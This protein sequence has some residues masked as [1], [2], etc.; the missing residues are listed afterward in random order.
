MLLAADRPRGDV[1]VAAGIRDRC[2]QRTPPRGG[3]DLGAGRVRRAPFA[4]D[5]TRLGIRDD[6]LA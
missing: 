3:V 5:R 1:G 6:D 4:H 2:F